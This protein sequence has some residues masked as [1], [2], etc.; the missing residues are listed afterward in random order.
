MGIVAMLCAGFACAEPGR[1]APPK[2]AA[3]DIRFD[4][5]DATQRWSVV[6]SASRAAWDPL[7]PSSSFTGTSRLDLREAL[8]GDTAQGRVA[9][10]WQR[11]E[12]AN[13]WA[14]YATA[15]G[16]EERL[17]Q[18]DAVAANGLDE[19][20]QQ[21]AR[22][23]TFAAGASI[24]SA[25]REI[26][27]RTSAETF[28][29]RAWLRNASAGLETVARREAFAASGTA[30]RWREDFRLPFG[31]ALALTLEPMAVQVADRSADVSAHAVRWTQ[32]LAGG[33]RWIAGLSRGLASETPSAFAL[34]DPRG[35]ALPLLSPLVRLQEREAGLEWQAHGWGRFQLTAFQASAPSDAVY[36]A[37]AWHLADRAFER[38][39]MR[40][41][42]R[43]D[44]ASLLELHADATYA[45]ARGDE[46]RG[47][48]EIFGNAGA[49]LR[50][51]KGWNA[52]L[53]VS[54]LGPRE[55]TGDDTTRI[56]STT[57]VNAQVGRRLGRNTRVSLSVFNVFDHRVQAVDAFTASRLAPPA[58]MGQAFLFSP[59]DERGFLL[60]LRTSF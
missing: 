46:R 60:R 36:E 18:D 25:G 40:V 30:I 9:F 54:Y 44:I 53:F 39:G 50:V 56:R 16:S 49:M 57:R 58:G 14:A 27:L 6:A 11:T 1:F 31:G 22:G 26:S 48:P 45:S 38:R 59:T 12:L 33:V 29:A 28:E 3:G 10:H 41:G 8:A 4:G 2:P 42:W 17:G 21:R 32:P 23:T 24:A 51:A 5:A 55:G 35:G 19:R 34:Q 13:R 43:Q 47:G 20:F 52:W 7:A 37:D 15:S